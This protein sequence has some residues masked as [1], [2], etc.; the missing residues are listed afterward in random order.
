MLG[1]QY[2]QSQFVG[3]N[4]YVNQEHFYKP[5]KTKQD[6]YLDDSYEC[7]FKKSNYKQNYTAK[8]DFCFYS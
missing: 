5:Y 1:Q 8:Q 2:Y 3:F 7:L 4:D 6:L